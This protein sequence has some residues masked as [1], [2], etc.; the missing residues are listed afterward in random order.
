M[1]SRKM[2]FS[3]GEKKESITSIN[4]ISLSTWKE[5]NY[6]LQLFPALFEP[7]LTVGVTVFLNCMYFCDFVK[8]NHELTHY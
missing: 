8:I 5:Y 6:F 1:Y 4:L 7:N 3:P 2:L